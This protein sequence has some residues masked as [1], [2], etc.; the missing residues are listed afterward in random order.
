M[1]PSRRGMYENN[2]STIDSELDWQYEDPDGTQRNRTPEEIVLEE[3]P[4]CTHIDS[5]AALAGRRRDRA[6]VNKVLKK[7]KAKKLHINKDDVWTYRLRAKASSLDFCTQVHATFSRETRN[8]IY[9]N[10]Y[11]DISEAPVSKHFGSCTSRDCPCCNPTLEIEGWPLDYAK[12]TPEHVIDVFDNHGHAFETMAETD[13]FKVVRP[14]Y[15]GAQFAR[16]YLEFIY[17]RLLFFFDERT[18]AILPR[19][20]DTPEP[21]FNL[22]PAD[23]VRDIELYA[24]ATHVAP[25]GHIT[26]DNMPPRDESIVLLMETL[27]TIRP[28]LARRNC[29]IGIRLFGRIPGVRKRNPK[30]PDFTHDG[31]FLTDTLWQLRRDGVGIVLRFEEQDVTPTESD[32]FEDYAKKIK[33]RAMV[34][35]RM[36]V[37]GFEQGRKGYWN[38]VEAGLIS[39]PDEPEEDVWKMMASL[40]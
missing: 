11:L 14:E 7:A 27:N 16:E 15:T 29:R 23:Y 35:D 6:W 40:S 1:R 28:L 10:L 4:D 21:I 30:V 20:L 18:M 38:D 22:R 26:K 34:E 12:Q 13:P 33:E 31:I 37:E 32:E 17:G 19:F 25:G 24:W 5:D 39:V 8:L 36:F 2:R 9:E 3:C